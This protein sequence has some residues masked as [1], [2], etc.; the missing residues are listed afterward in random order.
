MVYYGMSLTGTSHIKKGTV[1]QDSHKVAQLPNGWVAA[2]VADGVGSSKH[3]DIASRLAVDT[4]IE[5]CNNRID[6]HTKLSEVKEI[7]KNAYNEAQQRIAEYVYAHDD[8]L[9]DYDTTLHM[10]VYDGSGFVYGHAGDGGIVGLTNDGKYIKVTV[11]QKAEDNICVIPLRGGE[12]SWVI[13]EVKG[14][15]ASVLLATDGVYD[16]FYPY[17]LRGN[18][19]DVYVPLIRFFMDNNV[20]SATQDNI[21]EIQKS[22][23]EY[24]DSQAYESVSDDKTIVVIINQNVNPKLQEDAYYA[25]P[26]WAELELAWRKK[27]Y[28]HLYPQDIEYTGIRANQYVLEGKPFAVGKTCKIHS[29]KGNTASIAQIYDEKFATEELAAKLIHMMKHTPSRRVL[30]YVIWPQDLLYDSNNKFVGIILP[31]C[32]AIESLREVYEMGS[33]LNA[34]L[35][36]KA[37]IEVATSLC[38]VISAIHDAGYIVGNFNPESIFVDANK[39]QIYL[40]DPDSFL[41]QKE[42]SEWNMG[43][44]EYIPVEIHNGIQHG[45][46]SIGKAPQYTLESDYF[47]LAV[48]I[49]KIL[50]NGAHPFA[51]RIIN[52]QSDAECPQ[53]VD[54]IIEGYFPYV[55]KKSDLDIPVYAPHISI[56]P[57]DIQKLFYRA[58]VDGHT[59]PSSRPGPVE[60]E[61]SLGRLLKSL[62]NCNASPMHNYYKGLFKCPWC[63][64]EGPHNQSK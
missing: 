52:L 56:L 51:C 63:E 36:W 44:P 37:K 19:P 9:S 4:V 24:V 6:K 48:I 5:I 59:R 10:V 29:I 23:Q 20:L 34:T 41:I 62:T 47:A 30:P 7:V 43:L 53:P 26:N 8:E 2:A 1:C 12:T 60:W 61:K 33:K 45:N 64:L 49:F 40:M 3:S 17:L 58:F 21:Q 31:K 39:A 50:M 42:K 32:G 46:T 18:D 27:A 13:E 35:T 22:R 57:D 25:E 16:T 15:F 14:K 54:N 38:E 11:P 55:M 28:P